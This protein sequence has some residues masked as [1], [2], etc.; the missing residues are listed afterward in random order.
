MV[1]KKLQKKQG[2]S[3][4][5]KHT[6]QACVDIEKQKKSGMKGKKKTHSVWTAP[7]G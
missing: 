2:V 3:V 7:K 5:V 1:S 6:Y 4:T